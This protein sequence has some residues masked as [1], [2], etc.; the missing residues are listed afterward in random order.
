MLSSSRFVWNRSLLLGSNPCPALFG[1]R[2]TDVQAAP[3][4]QSL[5]KNRHRLLRD[6][7]ASSQLLI[8]RLRRGRLCLHLLP[9]H[10]NCPG[11]WLWIRHNLHAPI[12]RD[13][14]IAENDKHS[15]SI[16]ALFLVSPPVA[17]ARRHCVPSL[18]MCSPVHVLNPSQ[19][20]S[21]HFASSCC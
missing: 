17:E 21:H 1:L 10:W 2:L 8:P 13:T 15:V 18:T 11:H 7:D 9:Q 4:P 20:P 14:W 6:V 5:S 12:T 19:Y 16:P 3:A